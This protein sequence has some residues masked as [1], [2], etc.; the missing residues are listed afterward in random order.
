MDLV[1]ALAPALGMAWARP[2]NFSGPWFPCLQTAKEMPLQRV[3]R[4]SEVG[5][6][7]RKEYFPAS[8]ITSFCPGLGV[9]PP[10]PPPPKL[11]QLPLPP[12]L[13]WP[14]S[15]HGPGPGCGWQMEWGA[16]A[17]VIRADRNWKRPVGVTPA[18]PTPRDS[19]GAL[20][21]Q[22]ARAGAPAPATATSPAFLPHC[23]QE[24]RQDWPPAS[25]EWKCTSEKDPAGDPGEGSIPSLQHSLPSTPPSWSPHIQVQA[26]PAEGQGHVGKVY[27][28]LGWRLHLRPPRQ[29]VASGMSGCGRWETL[30]GEDVRVSSVSMWGF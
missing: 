3:E 7:G 27:R 16:A 4:P 13:G 22:A 9:I 28:G 5:T 25:P 2:P 1:P 20:N 21:L 6:A 23:S 17:I 11:D 19:G 18:L 8:P 24:P 26:L 12:S 29:Q 14:R 15:S 30:A 10:S